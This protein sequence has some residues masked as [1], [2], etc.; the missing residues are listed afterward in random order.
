METRADIKPVIEQLMQAAK[1]GDVVYIYWRPLRVIDAYD[2]WDLGPELLDD[3][4]IQV[5]RGEAHIDQPLAYIDV[6]DDLAGSSRVWFLYSRRYAEK[7]LDEVEIFR[8]A[9]DGKG[10]LISE[11]NATDAGAWLYDL[12]SDP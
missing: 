3:P 4:R 12:S 2:R 11:I 9:F 10:R 1:E 8:R 6:V 7:G 5:I